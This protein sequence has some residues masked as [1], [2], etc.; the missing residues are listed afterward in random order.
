MSARTEFLSRQSCTETNT[1]GPTSPGCCPGHVCVCVR[2]CVCST[3]SAKSPNSN[4]A[5]Y[6]PPQSVEK[7]AL[8]SAILYVLCMVR[9]RCSGAAWGVRTMVAIM[10][11]WVRASLCDA[12][13]R[14]L[15][16]PDRVFSDRFLFVIIAGAR[17]RAI[18]ADGRRHG[19]P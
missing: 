13:V 7:S 16:W 2:E 9:I 18:P 1:L 8:A 6:P 14:V 12:R 3:S 10:R 15:R 5:G 17:T 19:K 4:A 11:L